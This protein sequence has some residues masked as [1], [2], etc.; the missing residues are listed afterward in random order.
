M[1]S[2]FSLA[3]LL[4][5]S[6]CLSERSE[7][8]KQTAAKVEDSTS[9]GDSLPTY[10]KVLQRHYKQVVGYK[11]NYLIMSNGDSILYDDGVKKSQEQLLS[12]PDIQDM[13]AY[14]YRSP[15]QN[16]APSSDPGRIRNTAFFQAVY[17][18]TKRKVQDSLVSITWCP[19]IV[20]KRILVS[21]VNDVHKKF[22]LVSNELDNHPEWRPYLQ[23]IAGTFNWRTIRGTD[24][25][26]MHSYGVTIDIAVGKSD[27]W[28]WDCK[29]T[30][31]DKVLEYRNRVPL[32]IVKVFEKYGFIWGGNWYHYDTMHFEYRPE[33]LDSAITNDTLS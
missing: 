5:I 32:G 30:N 4:T 28:Q 18:T 31:E 3:L 11:N 25:L 33:L 17:G 7:I 14:T 13:F 6:A 8:G 29:C 27:Y 23:N 9:H 19:K 1:N 15:A 26:S 2:L 20:G 24:R 16:I 22:E 10:V 12:T 21:T